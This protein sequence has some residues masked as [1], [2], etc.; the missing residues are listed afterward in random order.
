MLALELL[1]MIAEIIGDF[2]VVLRASLQVT[3]AKWQ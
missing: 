1:Q 2:V 3:S